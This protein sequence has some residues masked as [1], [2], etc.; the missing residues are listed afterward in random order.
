MNFRERPARAL[1]ATLAATSLLLCDSFP[2]I[3]A[4]ADED[5]SGGESA[6]W[7]PKQVEFRY[8]GVTAVYTC[9]GLRSRVKYILQELG[10]RADLQ[11]RILGCTRRFA[12]ELFP[13]VSIKMS[14][15]QPAGPSGGEAVPSHW[16]SVDVLGKRGADAVNAAADC[17]LIRQI[18]E[19]VL[20]LFATREVD[21]SATC[22]AN[23]LL[24]GATRLKAEVLVP[25]SGTAA[26]RA[27]R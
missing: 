5:S 14:V 16:Q 27:S 9:D 24:V 2:T 12:P 22:Q 21:Y 23:N 8:Q 3:A 13:T 6:V 15:L 4:P 1:L 25:A 17:E 19:K 18:R 26:R 7:T 11:V 20:P 10:A